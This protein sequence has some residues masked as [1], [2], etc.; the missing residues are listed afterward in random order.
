MSGQAIRGHEGETSNLG[1]MLHERVFDVP[2][3]NEW[4]NKRDNWL[5]GETQNELLEIMAHSVQRNLLKNIHEAPFFSVIADGT[6][7]IFGMEQFAVCIRY[8]NKNFEP[9]EVFLGMYNA[10]DSTAKTLCRVIEDVAVRC[11]L[12]MNKPCTHCFD[13]AANMSGWLHGVTAELS[14]KHQSQC[15]FTVQII[16]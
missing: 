10:P 7:D 8:T 1:I 15:T 16:P 9:E 5:S 11:C 14:S 2:A 4:F 3:L 13:G 6:T 12:D